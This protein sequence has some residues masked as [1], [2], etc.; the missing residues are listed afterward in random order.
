MID[1]VEGGGDEMLREAGGDR[2]RR[3]DEREREREKERERERERVGV[4]VCVCM[5][6][7][8][9][10]HS[11]QQHSTQHHSTQQHSTRHT[12][13]TYL[14]EVGDRRGVFAI[15]PGA[16]LLVDTTRGQ[17]EEPV[18]YGNRLG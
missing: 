8:A 6:E 9:I 3:E 11:K 17:R 15:H 18:P 12:A 7:R 2:K 16:Y 10:V 1:V 5:G 14:P 13:L 4:W